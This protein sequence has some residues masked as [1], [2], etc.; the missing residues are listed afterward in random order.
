VAYTP[1]TIKYSVSNSTPTLLNVAEPAYSYTSNTLFIGTAGSDGAIAV[2]GQLYVAQQQIIFN[3]VNAAFSA[4]NS[5]G[6]GAASVYANGAFTAANS[7]G[8][9]ANAAFAKAN[10]NNLT[11]SLIDTIGNI[12]NVVSNVTTLRFDSDSGFDVNSLSQGIVKVGMNSTFKYW[13]VNGITYLTA[14]GIDT[15]NFL[16]TNG[17]TITADG[18]TTPQSIRFDGS[19]IFNVANSSAVYANASFAAA[20]TKFS[21]SGGTIAG[22]TNITGNLTVVGTTTYANTQTVLIADNILTLNAAIGQSA[23]P[24]VNA[25]IEVDRGAQPNA[26]FLWIETAGKWSANNGNNSIY[27]A[28]ESAESYANAAFLQANT[29]SYTSNSAAS[30]ANVAFATANTKFN[31]SGGTISGDVTVTGNIIPSASVTYNLGTPTNRWKDLYLSGTTINLGNARIESDETS[32]G[33]LL[34]PTP[35]AN[36]P[37]PTALFISSNGSLTTVQ[38]TG[39]IVTAANLEQAGANTANSVPVD[40]RINLAFNQAN[41]G[42]ETANSSA[43]Y[44]NSAFAAANSI[45]TN[46]KGGSF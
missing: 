18:G 35:T 45:T 29:P 6:S 14:E 40:V 13:Q 32:G 16:P 46:I 42:F 34:I 43:L 27:I 37:N 28:S 12:S 3:S 8:V 15:V 10:T 26:Q 22:D 9:Y 21:S 2:G 20:N 1:I 30:Y 36:V 44:A 5:A 41:S 38:T 25:G 7:A 11:V 23:Q 31:S 4:A 19:I 17:I 33:I 24:T 39:G